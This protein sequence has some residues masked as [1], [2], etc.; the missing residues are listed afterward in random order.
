ME[1]HPNPHRL[2]STQLGLPLRQR[3]RG[4]ARPNAGRKRG[5]RVSHRRRAPLAARFPVHVTLRVR[6]EVWNLRGKLCFR[7]LCGAFAGG[8]ER[9][10]FRLVH[11]AVL[12]N[13]L[14]LIVE[15]SDERALARGM[16]GLA[17]RMAR[18][19]N[20]E[21]ARKGPVFADR[22]HAHLLRSL[23]EV[24]NAVAYVLGNFAKH[25]AASGREVGSGFVDPCSSD[26][27]G[28]SA[29]VAPART[30]L[31]NRSD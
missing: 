29:L 15:A 18:S 16:Q 30:W 14:H 5:T 26:W 2:F 9:G 17:I 19:L 27:P 21:Q 28:L 7:A 24:R 23:A 31:L 22:Y 10:G 3:G 4:G 6:P 12:S 13:H 25:L 1:R 20:R 8:R 11:F